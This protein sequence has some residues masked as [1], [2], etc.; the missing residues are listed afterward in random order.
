[1]DMNVISNFLTNYGW[2]IALLAL[3]GILVVGFLKLVK[4]FDW[5]KVY[6]TQQDGTKVLNETKTKHVKKFIYY[7]LNCIISVSV[8]TI[9]VY[10]MR[11]IEIGDLNY[12]GV[13]VASVIAYS[14]TIYAVYE[15]F[16]IRTLC[17]I[18]GNGIKTAFSN[19][20]KSISAGK[21][22]KKDI[23][24]AINDAGQQTAQDIVDSITYA[25]QITI[26]DEVASPKTT[27]KK[28]SRVQDDD[29]TPGISE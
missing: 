18:I 7:A 25:Q 4:A 17:Q 22:S 10:F 11:G 3:S 24:Q 9:Y 29:F 20:T 19:V 16:G 12:W 23:Q 2:Q 5:I 21:T 1:M 15:N 27:I 8:C 14:T 6:T 26:E 28:V 13:M